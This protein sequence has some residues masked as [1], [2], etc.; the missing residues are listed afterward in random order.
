[1]STVQSARGKKFI[2][3]KT[4]Q[5]GGNTLVSRFLGLAREIILMRFLG[6]GVL[7]DAFTAA[8]LIPN[9]LRKI[10]AE[11]ALTAAFVPTFVTLFHKEGR[12]RANQLM[13]LSFVVFE[14]IVL[15]L[16]MVVMIYPA[17][18]TLL[19]MSGFSPEQVAATVPCLRIL[20]PF[21]FF[22]STSSLLAGAM[23]SVHHF[24]VPA[25]SP[26]LLNIF[27]IGGTLACIAYGWPVEYLCYAIMFGGLA[28]FLLHIYAYFYEGF[29]FAFPTKETFCYFGDV[30]KKFL[31]CFVSMSVMELNLIIDQKFASFL[32]PGSVTLIKYSSR[33]MGIPLGVFAV[34]FSTILLPHFSRVR[35]YAPSRLSFYLLE[36]MKLVLWV[37]LPATL[38]MGYL[39]EEIFQTLFASVSSKF[40]AAMVPEAGTMLLGFLLGLFFFSINKILFSLFYS[41]HD[42]R[43]PTIIAAVATV[44][45][46]GLNYVLVNAFGGFGLAIATSISG[47]IQMLLCLLLL[48]R[49]HKFTLYP[50]RFGA[51]LL[52]YT[53]QVIIVLLPFL[54][55]Y[56]VSLA[57]MNR[58]LTGNTMRFFFLKSFGYWIWVA[59]LMVACFF[60]LY[61]TRK[62]FKVK[63]YFLD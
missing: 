27:F 26:I 36:S 22:V 42:T 34:A 8:F 9:S 62:L 7:A 31:P 11:G 48:S 10:F 37:T 33:F 18:T 5:V 3:S 15:L 4:V 43:Y 51:F 24:F 17:E 2:I 57:A 30:V 21:I 46:I 32:H 61:V 55:L 6:V 38:I 13:A 39:S 53:L 40:P 16:C 19:I 25:F 35:M 44:A 49:V 29:S 45:N 1:M 54:G 20:M 59:P 12:E 58:L 56:H 41:M 14:G 52:R 28:Q 60:C 63:L 47:A 50:G 23:N